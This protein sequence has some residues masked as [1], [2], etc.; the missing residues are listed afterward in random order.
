MAET[1]IALALA[2]ALAWPA[3][4]RSPTRPASTRT[5]AK[6]PARPP[7]HVPGIPASGPVTPP[8][9][10]PSSTPS[11]SSAPEPSVPKD[12]SQGPAPN[13]ADPSAPGAALPTPGIEGPARG[14][15]AP[16]P[17]RDLCNG[18]RPCQRLVILGSVTG[19]LG[20]A[21][22]VTGAVLAS[23]PIRVDGADPTMAITYRPAGTAV[24]TIGVG[25]LATSVLM[26]LAAT[27]ASRQARRSGSL[28]RWSAPRGRA[29]LSW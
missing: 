13:R 2:L 16:L 9:P 1:G 12:M 23:R 11:T 26:A 15:A 28:A 25:V 19:A 21:T 14:P 18:S 5:P 22:I 6:A 7:S 3:P 27:R 20:L 10:P 8:A 24:L 4:A 17:V 29:M